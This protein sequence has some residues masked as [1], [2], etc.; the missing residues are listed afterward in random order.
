MEHHGG[1]GSSRGRK[2]AAANKLQ[3][4][5]HL[6]QLQQQQSLANL[7]GL[8]EL[9]RQGGGGQSQGQQ[10]QAAAGALAEL[11]GEWVKI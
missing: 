7:G 2:N 4:A 5:H 11:F 3:Q 6:H 10:Q 9:A 8:M 1:K